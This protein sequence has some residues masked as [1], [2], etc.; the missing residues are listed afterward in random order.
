MESRKI[1]NHIESIHP[2]PSL[3][4]DSPY[5]SKIEAL[6]P[7]VMGAF[8]GAFLPLVPVRLLNERS[9]GYWYETRER[10]AGMPLDKLDGAK[11]LKDVVRPLNEVSK[12]LRRK[13]R[14]SWVRKSAM[15]IWC[16][17]VS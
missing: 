12:L 7:Q 10:M 17:S 3:H 9:Q 16:L 15:R 11:A 2:S 1:A 13:G 14:F 4:L 6:M 5:L 8:R